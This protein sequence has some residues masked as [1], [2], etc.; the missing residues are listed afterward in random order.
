M[1]CLLCHSYAD[2]ETVSSVTRR[3]RTSK[4]VSVSP[5]TSSAVVSI[6]SVSTWPSIMISPVMLTP[7][8]IVLVV[9]AVSELRVFRS[10]SS[11]VRP[12]KKY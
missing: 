7:T 5:P 10:R 12:I 2:R 8:F 6:L 9:P 11:A 3:S 4:S 1:G